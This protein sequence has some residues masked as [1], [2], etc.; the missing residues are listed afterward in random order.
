[1]GQEEIVN[2]GI[3]CIKNED[4]FLICQSGISKNFVWEFPGGKFLPGEN[5]IDCVK[6]EVNEEL[7]IDVE[8]NP[9]FLETE[10]KTSDK[11]FRLYFCICRIISGI[12][13][14]HEHLQY[15]WV[16]GVKLT[17]YKFHAAN[18]SAIE[19]LKDL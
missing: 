8:V 13:E 12:P 19:M 9:H 7:S 10:S 1:M 18:S 17:D 15:L 11:T 2:V 16:P 14:L 6:R 3:A 5:L 4:S